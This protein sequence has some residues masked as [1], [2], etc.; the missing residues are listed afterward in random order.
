MDRF[1]DHALVCPCKGDRTVRH[2]AIRNVAY[3]EAVEAGFAAEREKAG[4]L[5]GRPTEDGLPGVEGQRRPADLWL[6]RSRGSRG[7]ALD[8]ACSSGMRADYLQAIP[9]DPQHVFDQYEHLK[10]TYKNT[11]NECESQGFTFTPMIVEA[12]AG[13]W[14][15]TAKQVWDRMAKLQSATWNEQGNT[16]SIRIAQRLS[17]ALH[18]ENARTVLRR[19][20]PSLDPG[21]PPSAWDEHADQG[22][23]AEGEV[24]ADILMDELVEV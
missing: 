22:W 10:R 15:P 18:R 21:D 16:S 7:E 13:G 24:A 14:S 6:P 12:H 23:Y 4:L 3:T 19:T 17:I 1:G 5:P 9:D 11:E 8:F 20:P 2:N